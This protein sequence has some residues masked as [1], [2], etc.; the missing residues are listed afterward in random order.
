MA[1]P[2]SQGEESHRSTSFLDAIHRLRYQVYCLERQ[3]LD[4]SAH[5]EG[6]ERDEFD[7]YSVHFAATDESGEV[8]ATLRLVLDS[9]LGFPLEHR[10]AALAPEFGT[11]PRSRT[12]EISRLILATPHRGTMVADP[13][14]LFGLLRELY[15]ESRRR[16]LHGFLASMEPRLARL[17]RRLGFPFSPIGPAMEYFGIV[18]P[19]W[20]ALDALEVGYRKVL[21]HLQHVAERTTILRYSDLRTPEAEESG[22]AQQWTPAGA[23]D[24]MDGSLMVTSHPDQVD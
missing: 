6:R 15:E 24:D 7:R 1:S 20:T 21:V 13:A 3:F 22:L 5:P 14:L 12:G 11:L 8:V 23:V 2:T 18:T 9:S 10:A 16:G 17:L 4:L 19:Y